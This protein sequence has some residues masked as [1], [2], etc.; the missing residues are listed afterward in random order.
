MSDLQVEAASI[1]LTETKSRTAA[2][3]AW[4]ELRRNGIF[5][6][7]VVLIVGI[8]TIVLFPGLFANEEATS[9]LTG[10]CQLENSLEG[11]G[12]EFLLGA[13][14]QGCDIYSLSIYSARPS[15]TIGLLTA[16]GTTLVGSL[17]GLISGYNGG[18]LDSFL[19]GVTSVFLGLPF[20]LGAI[21][22]LSSIDLPDIWGVILALTLMSWP[23]IFRL[24]RAKT[25]EAKGQDYTLAARA[26]GAKNLRIMIR[27]ILPNAIGPA[28]AVT[29]IN[30]GIFIGAEATISYLGLGIQPPAISWGV[31]IS[32]AQQSFFAAPWTLLV[33]AGFLTVTVLA[34]IL[35]GETVRDAL[36]PK[37]RK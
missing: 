21:V 3:D 17:L 23:L 30:L 8:M 25:I 15:V 14:Q 4:F 13:D 2:G 20:V 5:W 1:E 27:H 24:I 10:G 34:F 33:P 22:L 19:S 32:E 29:V 36:D 6:V 7:S 28:I 26:L 35:L 37:M 9:S 31:M 16:L 11:P 12:S 18:K